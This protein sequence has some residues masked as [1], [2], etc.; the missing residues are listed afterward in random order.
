LLEITV[1]E[2]DAGKVQECI[3]FVCFSVRVRLRITT[4][5]VVVAVA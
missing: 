3:V 1:V 4:V 2:T 5:V